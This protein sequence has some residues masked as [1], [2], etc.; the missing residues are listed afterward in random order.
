ML[1]EAG[2]LGPRHGQTDGRLLLH[3][4]SEECCTT[5]AHSLKAVSPFQAFE[6]SSKRLLW[7]TH[8]LL[9]RYHDM[10]DVIDFL[11]LRQQFDNARQRQWMIG[12]CYSASKYLD[13]SVNI[14][15]CV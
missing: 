15:V 5:Y 2:L 1:S 14:S 8:A 12:L 3:E 10:P 9:H 13:F 6:K 7:L 11:V 4:V